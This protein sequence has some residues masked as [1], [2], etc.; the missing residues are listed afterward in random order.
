MY[1]LK[2]KDLNGVWQTVDFGDDKPYMNFQMG[3]IAKLENRKANYSQAL[4]LPITNKNAI[5]F[6]FS[7]VIQSASK[8]PYRPF[9]CRLYANG[10]ELVDRGAFLRII[11][12]DTI[13]NVFETQ[14]LSGV[15]DF[16]S[17]LKS[18]R[19]ANLDLGTFVLSSW[20]EKA[21][22]T[23]ID[24]VDYQYCVYRT[25]VYTRDI[26]TQA[27]FPP[28]V[29]AS[30]VLDK[31]ME[32]IPFSLQHDMQ[33][34][35]DLVIPINHFRPTEGF[36][37]A[38]N[39]IGA[40]SFG[41]IPSVSSGVQTR[42]AQPIIIN[43]ALGSLTSSGSGYSDYAAVYKATVKGTYKITGNI[44]ANFIFSFVYLVVT[45]TSSGTSEEIQLSTTP[46]YVEVD[47]EAEEDDNITIQIRGTNYS[48]PS[49]TVTPVGTI[50]ITPTEIEQIPISGTVDIAPRLGY[51]TAFDFFKML[52]EL[53]G[54]MFDMRESGVIKMYGLNTVVNN[55][56]IA[57]DWSG[58][59][60]TQGHRR[61]FTLPY[62]QNNT[63]SFKPAKRD[64]N[65][66]IT[67]SFSV[68]D[69]TLEKEKELFEVP[70]TSDVNVND[71]FLPDNTPRTTVGVVP[72]FPE[73]GTPDE[74]LSW[75]NPHNLDGP[76]VLKAE[77]IQGYFS[78]EFYWR[79][80]HI[81]LQNQIDN[82]YNAVI[83]NMLNYCKVIEID[84]NLS[85]EDVA[86][87]DPFVP[88]FIKQ[89]SKYFYVSKIRNF[90]AGRLTRCELVKL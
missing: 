31:I 12:I 88:I 67:A 68:D 82:R 81:N 39:R 22:D 43:N 90:V 45:N 30:F 46:K 28:L 35:E 20:S 73:T 70:I 66:K 55:K 6:G 15:L 61:T 72:Y 76:Y 53:H 38:S 62:A 26:S 10:Y 16:V 79:A 65:I 71:A 40:T 19:L 47:I 18:I 34:I 58:K 4:K 14:I 29:R 54:T 52:M 21:F 3:E 77:K 44:S 87:H 89:F 48:A 9:D 49:G 57:H 24:R 75:R 74:V 85:P 69:T 56:P 64:E 80:I 7:D 27:A 25:S 51:E 86:N 8:A 63:I 13:N 84:V 11:A 60:S 59:V 78:E 50:T 2:I 1:E 37:H 42:Y 17:V 5:L 83:N 32:A 41:V 33:G 36:D 23:A